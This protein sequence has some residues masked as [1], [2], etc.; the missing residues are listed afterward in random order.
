MVKECQCELCPLKYRNPI[1]NSDN[2]ED[3]KLSADQFMEWVKDIS[4]GNGPRCLEDERKFCYSAVLLVLG[5]NKISDHQWHWFQD[6]VNMADLCKTFTLTEA[7]AYYA[8]LLTEQNSLD[9][10]KANTILFLENEEL[11]DFLENFEL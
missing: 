7:F 10:D 4:N 9:R 8:N 3:I 11:L 5:N 2:I 6:N 1:G